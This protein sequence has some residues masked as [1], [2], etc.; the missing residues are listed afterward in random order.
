MDA[1]GLS[2]R[3]K[4][5]LQLAKLASP[6][7]GKPAALWTRVLL[8][9][10]RCRDLDAGLTAVELARKSGVSVDLNMMTT[11][12]K[13]AAQSMRGPLHRAAPY[14][15]GDLSSAH[16]GPAVCKAVGNVDKAYRVY[17]DMRAARLSIDGHVYGL[18]IATCAEAMKRDLTVV[19]ERKDQ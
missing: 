3:A 4:P 1:V 13:G 2:G 6:Y 12:L 9:C 18:L 5:A 7:V 11:L 8:A 10:S 15:P 19:H 16:A 14:G 17:L